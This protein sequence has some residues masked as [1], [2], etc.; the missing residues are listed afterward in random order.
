MTLHPILR[1]QVL[2]DAIDDA[3]STYGKAEYSRIYSFLTEDTML[4]RLKTCV[5][6]LNAAIA[7]QF[8][9]TQGLPEDLHSACETL[10]HLTCDLPEHQTKLIHQFRKLVRCCR[11]P[12]SQLD[13]HSL[14][15]RGRCLAREPWHYHWY[16]QPRSCTCDASAAVAW[17]LLFCCTAAYS[18]WQ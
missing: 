3:L 12:F 10:K 13:M 17:L 16:W 5:A 8:S 11:A 9:T 4:A 6:K 1:T 14:I 15:A 7:Q 18:A 2:T